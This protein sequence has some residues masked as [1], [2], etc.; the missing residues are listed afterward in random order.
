MW[1][2]RI[3]RHALVLLTTLVLGGFLGATLVRF[4][5]GFGVDERELDTR[6]RND[7]IQTIR[8]SRTSENNIARFYAHYLAGLAHGDLGLSRSLGRPVSELLRER[9]PATLR[10]V[11]LGL[12]GGWLL[13]FALALP[14]AARCGWW[15]DLAATVLS[16]LFLCLPI[17]VLGILLLY[18][19]GPGP[20][21]IAAVV[22]PR[23]FRYSR[24]LLSRAYNLPH[25]LTARAKGLRGARILLFHVLP[26]AAPQLLALAATSVSV[27][28][29]AVIPIEA[30]CDS[31]GIGQLAWQAA[32]ARDLPVLVNVTLLVTLVTL[33]MS[34]LSDLAA[35]VFLRQ[36]A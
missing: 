7:S 31:P 2:T 14:G 21:A 23:A 17:A 8:Q 16:G 30:I 26:C 9:A 25:V 19:G 4:G 32:L 34:S 12:L 33:T 10:W 29:S 6:L 35:R 27:G 1:T 28:L 24:N 22:F 20:L 15:F 13:G 11:V 3:V 18:V 36:A 5:P